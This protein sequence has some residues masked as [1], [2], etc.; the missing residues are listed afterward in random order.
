[1]MTF[2][3]KSPKASD[4]QSGTPRPRKDAG[5]ASDESGIPVSLSIQAKPAAKAIEKNRIVSSTEPNMAAAKGA[6]HQVLRRRRSK[7]VMSISCAKRKA[8]PE[9]IAM[10]G[11]ASQIDI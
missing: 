4:A 8:E 10:R 3:K 6:F 1:M 11:V 9:A 7:T 5:S 2:T